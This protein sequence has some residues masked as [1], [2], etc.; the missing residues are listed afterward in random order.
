M[1]V[2]E[3][4]TS[5]GTRERY[6]S[7]VVFKTRDL[8][9]QSQLVEFIVPTRQDFASFRQTESAVAATGHGGDGGTFGD[10]HLGK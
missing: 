1:S 3:T 6:L 9:V 2:S 4:S 5:N 10:V 7:R 8:L